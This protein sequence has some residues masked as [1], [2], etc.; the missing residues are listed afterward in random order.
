M[1]RPATLPPRFHPIAIYERGG[2]SCGW[3][4]GCGFPRYLAGQF[5]R[6]V[7]RRECVVMAWSAEVLRVAQDDRAA[8]GDG[9]LVILF[10]CF[11]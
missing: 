11:L 10:L 6:L 7:R 5:S 8:Q 1:G 3:H 9:A 4:A 2:V